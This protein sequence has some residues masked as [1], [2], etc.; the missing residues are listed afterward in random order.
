MDA[1]EEE[2]LEQ[3]YFRALAA[4]ERGNV[5]LARREF[6]IMVL[7]APDFAPAWDGLG[8]CLV[9][10]GEPSKAGECFRRAIRVDRGNWASR[11]HW[12]S[13]LRRAGRLHDACRLLREAVRVA[14]RERRVHYELGQCL[15]EI[16]DSAG[17]VQAFQTAL[18]QPEREVRD[19]QLHVALGAAEAERGDVEAA[20]AAFER[21]C[22]LA[23]EDP[24]IYYQWALLCA[25]SGDA[26]NAERLAN[27]A[28]ALDRGSRR[29]S[30]LLVRIA[31]RAGEWDRAESRIRDLEAQT[32]THA[33]ARALRA[34]LAS[35]REDSAVART[36]AFDALRAE[37]PPDDQATAIALAVLRHPRPPQPGLQGFRLVL[38]VE[39][40][41]EVYYRPYVL[42]AGDEEQAQ[43]FVAELQDELDPS[44]WRVL[45]SESFDHEG[46]AVPGVYQVLLRRV[47]FPRAH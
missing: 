29:S 8:R 32:D 25:D 41:P 2:D 36:L 10:E 9:A 24:E 6:D 47:L 39:R 14:P 22:L 33:L 45:E 23:P 21:A 15:A 35:R 12:A 13:S 31:L 1:P 27:R 16:G 37:V 4:L 42:L 19:S 3:R 38:E 30:V 44:P 46:E 11:C 17:A 20:D 43:E 40:G 5:P 7:D 26:L 18:E 28:K 34:E